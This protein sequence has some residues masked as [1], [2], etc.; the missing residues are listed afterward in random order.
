MADNEYFPFFL[1]QQKVLAYAPKPASFLSI[2]CSIFLIQRILRDPLRRG[3]VYHRIILVLSVH[4]SILCFALFLGTWPMP[5]DSLS[6]V[7]GAMGTNVTCKVQGFIVVF[8][9][10]TVASFY[11][12]LSL[13]SF[14]AV[15]N[16]FSE[17]KLR[18]YEFWLHIL[19]Y[20]VPLSMSCIALKKN[21]INPAGNVCFIANLPFG[22]GYNSDNP[23]IDGYSGFRR[24]SSI[25][26]AYFCLTIIVAIS[27]TLSL[28][29]SVR[30]K[31]RKNERL[32]GKR[33]HRKNK[34]KSRV[35][36][37]Q[38]SLY[39]GSFICTY[40]FPVITRT[41]TLLS[42]K[43]SFPLYAISPIMLGLH[44]VL[45]LFVYH[46]LL[47][48]RSPFAVVPGQP[49]LER[50]ERRV[51]FAGSSER[52]PEIPTS[53]PGCSP[54]ILCIKDQPE[55]SIFDGTNAS[56]VWGEFIHESSDCD[57]DAKPED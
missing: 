10:S 2:A 51:S 54:K 49:K 3:K 22:C 5:K 11:L 47:L 6:A 37:T 21:F 19:I 9:S 29:F 48:K 18:K 12:S 38:A 17:K 25:S 15:R 53:R 52:K 42:G 34:M 28:Y 57:E 1:N 4:T 36:A 39:F 7:Y 46:R 40:T 24:F 44:G 14:L 43:F 31:E 50:I 20:I 32:Y 23:C 55:F 35:I 16:D 13:F 45:N 56:D 26:S 41:H 33:K 27:L 30:K 8:E